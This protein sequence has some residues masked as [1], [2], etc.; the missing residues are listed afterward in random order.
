MAWTAQDWG[1][2]IGPLT[3]LLGT[4]GALLFT[5]YRTKSRG[6]E[7]KILDIFI[8]SITEIKAG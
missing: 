5:Y 4:I 2:I 1:V 3:A 8:D 7:F 6:P